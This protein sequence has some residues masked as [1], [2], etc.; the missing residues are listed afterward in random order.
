MDFDDM[1]KVE[2]YDSS[3]FFVYVLLI[4]LVIYFY[5]QFW[6]KPFM[7]KIKANKKHK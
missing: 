5:V 7:Q 2:Y 6:H 3:E 4:P 1:F